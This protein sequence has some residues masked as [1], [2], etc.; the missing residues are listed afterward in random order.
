VTVLNIVRSKLPT[1]KF[2]FL[3]ACHSRTGGRQRCR[4]G[5]PPFRSSVIL[6]IPQRNR[7]NVSSGR[8]RRTGSC[9]R[10]NFTDLCSQTDEKGC[11]T[12]RERRRRF[13]T[14]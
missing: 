5:A 4:R 14:L 13:G 3:S 10:R 12:T 9:Y 2:A 1:A 11:R 6:W 8:H 7:D